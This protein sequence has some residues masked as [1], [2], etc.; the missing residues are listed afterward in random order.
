[1]YWPAASHMSHMHAHNQ[2]SFS[3]LVND[4]KW[5]MC[6]YGLRVGSIGSGSGYAKFWEVFVDTWIRSEK[7]RVAWIQNWAPVVKKVYFLSFV[8]PPLLI[9]NKKYWYLKWYLGTRYDKS[10]KPLKSDTQT[11]GVSYTQ[12][13]YI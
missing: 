3:E 11:R 10:G 9:R 4:F 5:F 7:Y 6:R 1:M 13:V 8:W 2:T 12:K